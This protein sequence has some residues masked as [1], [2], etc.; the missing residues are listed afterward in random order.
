MYSYKN[1][2]AKEKKSKRIAA[3]V[4][5]AL[6]VIG[7]G[8][9]LVLKNHSKNTKNTPITAQSEGKVNLS[10]PTQSDINDV[11]RH[12]EE[13]VQQDEAI[14]NNTQT[15]KIKTVPLI[16]TSSDAE[17]RNRVTAYVTG[18]F[19]DGGTCNA[20]ATN[21]P[22]SISATSTGFENVS[23]TQCAPL[24]WSQTLSSGN[25]SISVSYKSSTAE[26]TQTKTVKVQ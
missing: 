1:K 12:K 23:Y 22:Q 10:P 24:E 7:S 8:T 21:G 17:T 14:K 19:E 5:V 18:V 6:L 13:I 3:L 11:N 15:G 26:G 9:Y 20:T 4:L 2:N 25:W 16:I